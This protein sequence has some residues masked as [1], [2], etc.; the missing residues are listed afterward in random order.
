MITWSV[1][2]GEARWLKEPISVIRLGEGLSKQGAFGEVLASLSKRKGGN[3]VP[4]F[5]DRINHSYYA[6]LPTQRY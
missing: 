5:K 1:Y 2:V 6:T 3:K 4:I